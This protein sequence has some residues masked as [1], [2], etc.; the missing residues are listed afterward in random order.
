M[1][2]CHRYSVAQALGSKPEVWFAGQHHLRVARRGRRR[3]HI[4]AQFVHESG[5]FRHREKCRHVDDDESQPIPRLY[6]EDAG[7]GQQSSQDLDQKCQRVAAVAFGASERENRTARRPIEL[8]GVGCGQA[9]GIHNGSGLQRLAG[10][11]VHTDE[12]L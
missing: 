2:S 5:E 7:T 9:F 3:F 4:L 10:L 12:A 8:G 1:A 11:A 6:L